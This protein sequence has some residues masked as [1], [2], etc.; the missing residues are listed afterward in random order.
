MPST[1]SHL[2]PVER[3]VLAMSADGLTVGEIASRLRRSEGHVVRLIR[4]TKI[5]RSGP[6][7]RRSPRAIERRVLALR[8]NGESHEQIAARF[9]RSPRYIRQVEGL[10]HVRHGGGSD[11]VD[12][13]MELLAEVSGE[14]RTAA[15]GESSGEQS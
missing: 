10:A 3:R 15:R 14:A 12:Q 5:P 11:A 8:R 9:R 13:G 2:R 6:S 1:E 4:W 7:R